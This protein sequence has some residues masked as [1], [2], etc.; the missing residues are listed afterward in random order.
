MRMQE[1]DQLYM[2]D[3]DSSFGKMSMEQGRPTTAKTSEPSSKKSPGS[4]I[5]MPLYLNLR[6][7]NGHQPDVSWEI[8][9]ALLGEYSMHSFGEAPTFLPTEWRL[10]SEHRNGV[11]ESR[12]SQ[13]LVD[14]APPRYFLSEKACQGVLNRSQ[15]RGKTLPEVLKK[16]LENQAKQ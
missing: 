15:R 10:N 3:P 1:L 7:E 14:N 13:I 6:K 12:L 16:A 2:F 8:G 4:S 9:G 11:A 5:K